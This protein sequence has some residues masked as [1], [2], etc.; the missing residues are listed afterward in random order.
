MADGVR[1]LRALASLAWRADRA[2]A[3]GL[4]AVSVVGEASG[5]GV[6]VALKMLTNAAAQGDRS[7]AMVAAVLAGVLLGVGNVGSWSSMVLR[8]GLWERATLAVDRRLTE[9]TGGMPGLE[10]H[11]N[12]AYLKE[13]EI[14]RWEH[15]SLTRLGE[16]M[17]ASVSIVVRFAA[18]LALLSGVYPALALLPL[19][20]VPSLVAGIA[21]ERVRHDVED[22]VASR[23][24]LDFRMYTMALAP[25]AAKELRVL[26]LRDEVM[27]RYEVALAAADALEDDADWRIAGYTAAGWLA[28]ATGFVGALVVVAEQVVDGRATP[29]D[30]VLALSL[31]AQ[32]NS[33]VAGLVG[34]TS[35]LMRDLKT[36][37]RYLW[38]VDRFEAARAEA[39]PADPAPAPVTL[40]EGIRLEHVSFRYSGT[41]KDVLQDVDLH[42]PA[43]STVA[44]VGENGAGKTSLVK[45]VCRFYEPTEGR[46]VVDGVDLRRIDVAAWRRRLAGAFQDACRLELVASETVGAGDLPRID[47]LD[48]VGAALTRAHAEEL[49]SQLSTG[50]ST[51]LG[52]SFE[53]G[54]ELSTGQ[55]Q[56]LALARALMR[57]KPLILV[58]DEPA[59]AL[60]AETEHALLTRYTGAARAASVAAGAI[61]LLV[62]HRFSTV[63]FA[64]LIVVLD[65][66]RVREVGSHVSLIE[67]GGLYAEMF[68]LQARAYS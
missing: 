17:V 49:P 20:G 33:G 5:L 55:W 1:A 44:L 61:T 7:S 3:A 40:A 6:A 52:R 30:F 48:A 21:A 53:N 34:V 58:L 43:G 57:E 66:G 67:A 36:G 25:D 2:R 22:K 60:D 39:R 38:L 59:A 46:I 41:D 27:A 12:P 32:V 15:N 24:R 35:R 10:H 4:L 65:E 16:S 29:G 62:S 63:R 18:S 56:K 23:R 42:L 11:E 9:L 45:L 14:L 19:F 54:A 8:T 28:F 68:A 31:A 47:D 50:L 13:M 26:G 64:D 37:S 51:H